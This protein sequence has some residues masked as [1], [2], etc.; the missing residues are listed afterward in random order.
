MAE[1]LGTALGI[2]EVGED[3]EDHQ[4]RPLA[5]HHHVPQCHISPVSG[6]PLMDVNALLPTIG[7]LLAPV[8]AH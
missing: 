4:V 2:A 8:N 6:K 3:H 5:H 1:N 7:P